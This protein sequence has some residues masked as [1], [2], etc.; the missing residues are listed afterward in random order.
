MYKVSLKARNLV[1]E[2]ITFQDFFVQEYIAGFQL[3]H[4]VASVE[5][6][7]PTII[8]WQIEYGTDVTYVVDLGKNFTRHDNVALFKI[9][10]TW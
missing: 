6:G 9:R 3:L 5:P 4:R 7:N 8:S 1:S 2:F 10:I